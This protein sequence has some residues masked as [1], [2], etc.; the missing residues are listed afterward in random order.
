MLVEGGVIVDVGHWLPA[1]QPAAIVEASAR[2]FTD[3]D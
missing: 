2:F 3:D 1:D